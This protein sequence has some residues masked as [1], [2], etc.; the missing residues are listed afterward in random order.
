MAKSR[1]LTVMETEF[2]AAYVKT[3]KRVEA[4]LQAGYAPEYADKNSSKLL[5]SPL[6][7]KAIVKAKKEI[8]SDAVLEAKDITKLCELFALSD[9]RDYFTIKNGSIWVNDLSKLTKEQAYCIQS[10]QE[11]KSGIK[12][13][14]VSKADATDMLNK[15]HGNYEK[16][17]KQKE[18]NVIINNN[19]VAISQDIYMQQVAKE[20]GLIY[21]DG[22]LIKQEDVKND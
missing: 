10:I 1:K 12:I 11:T 6:I 18:G 22:Q 15:I 3:H 5:Q 19:V 14:L 2:V 17:N 4:Y 16:D 8:L 7:K 21:K 9:I 13:N 20:Q